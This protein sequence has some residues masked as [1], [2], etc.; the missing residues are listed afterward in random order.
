LD[1]VHGTMRQ[2]QYITVLKDRMLPQL[3]IWYSNDDTTC[4]QDGAP[5]HTAKRVLD[6]L[7]ENDV[8]VLRWLGNS[9][10]MN[11]LENLWCLL[12]RK[13]NAVQP[14]TTKRALIESFIHV[15]NHNPDIQEI[16]PLFYKWDG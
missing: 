5:C 16:C 1:I 11:P 10:D 6:F 14:V 3:R 7:T 9:S 8:P 2:D 12:K 15:W 4:M 13:I